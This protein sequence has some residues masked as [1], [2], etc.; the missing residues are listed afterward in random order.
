MSLT[1]S[2]PPSAPDT[3][4][5]VYASAASPKFQPSDQTA[6]LNT[7]RKRNAEIDVTGMLLFVE[8]SFL[9]V[10]EGEVAVLDALLARIRSDSRHDK[11]VLLLR[12]QIQARSFADWTMGFTKLTQAD[13]QNA[14]GVS[15]VSRAAAFS[16]LGDSKVRRL[17]ELFR[18]GSY[19]QRIG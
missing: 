3:W 19:R 11:V 2:I 17:L 18:S 14:L 6:I 9:Q 1:E 15:D 12:E 13:L 5:L 10:L 8:G 4:Q 7:A 16:T